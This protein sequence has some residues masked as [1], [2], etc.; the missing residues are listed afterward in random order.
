MISVGFSV[1]VRNR[2]FVCHRDKEV[3]VSSLQR[4]V[5]NRLPAGKQVSPSGL[6]IPLR[7]LRQ[8][9]LPLSWDTLYFLLTG[10]SLTHSDND[11]RPPRSFV[12]NSKLHFLGLGGRTTAPKP[13]TTINHQ[14]DVP[15]RI[16]F[17]SD[18]STGRIESNLPLRSFRLVYPIS[19]NIRSIE[20][21]LLWIRCWWI[22]GDTVV[23]HGTECPPSIR[24]R[25]ILG[26]LGTVK[27]LGRW[28][29]GRRMT[30]N[31][32]RR[33]NLSREGK[34][35]EISGWVNERN[36]FGKV[37]GFRLSQLGKSYSDKVQK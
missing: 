2:K 24:P 35:L 10:P 28:R 7:R 3:P 21:S 4:S 34:K 18:K 1:V 20:T 33:W 15:R 14:P 6:G 31:P 16:R 19:G 29:T 32:I 12:Q 13:T 30:L 8:R 36:H 11:P 25:E 17:I 26:G 5:V 9:T 27:G 22:R 37:T 23:L